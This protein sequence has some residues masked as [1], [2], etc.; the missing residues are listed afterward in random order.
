MAFLWNTICTAT[1]IQYNM[2]G[3][4]HITGKDAITITCTLASYNETII[5]T[6]TAQSAIKYA[7]E[8]FFQFLKHSHT[9]S[10]NKKNSSQGQQITTISK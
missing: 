10:L 2:S 3:I 8:L 6:T 7:M 9:P 1:T 4:H 5:S